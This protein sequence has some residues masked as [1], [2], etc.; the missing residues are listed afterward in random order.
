SPAPPSS[1]SPQLA[2]VDSA[3]QTPEEAEDA[4]DQAA[5]PDAA[6][7]AAPR[8]EALELMFETLRASIEGVFVEEADTPLG[9]A[10]D[11]AKSYTDLLDSLSREIGEGL[12]HARSGARFSMYGDGSVRSLDESLLEIFRRACRLQFRTVTSAGL[13]SDAAPLRKRV[14]VACQKHGQV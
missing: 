4:E 3:P 7:A 10:A 11:Q 5:L 8:R 2:I 12:R 9:A 14:L 6:L 1:L 13:S